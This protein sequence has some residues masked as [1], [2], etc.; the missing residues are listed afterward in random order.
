METRHDLSKSV[1]I[2][3]KAEKTTFWEGRMA[4]NF[5]HDLGMGVQ[6]WEAWPQGLGRGGGGGAAAGLQRVQREACPCEIGRVSDLS[7]A[8]LEVARHSRTTC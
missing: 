8:R 5:P 4:A 6:L 2:G 1:S 7:T 3:N